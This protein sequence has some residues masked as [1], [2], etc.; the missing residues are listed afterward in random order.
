MHHIS[1][2][3]MSFCYCFSGIKKN[4]K[5]H[6]TFY[7][8]N[9]LCSYFLETQ[10]YLLALS[11][12]LTEHLLGNKQLTSSCFHQIPRDHRASHGNINST[13]GALVI[14]TG[15]I[16]FSLE[17]HTAITDLTHIMSILNPRQ[18]IWD[19]Q[20]KKATA[21]MTY[22]IMNLFLRKFSC[23]FSKVPR[24]T[25]GRRCLSRKVSVKT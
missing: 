12:E 3:L 23:N 2:N 16:S 6:Q 11:L 7:Q 22:K 8:H 13:S 9:C 15:I 19:L 18:E 10:W 25:V 17:R 14:L 20:H 5:P 21:E 4:P 24:A 1:L